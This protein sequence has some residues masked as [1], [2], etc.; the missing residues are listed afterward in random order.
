MYEWSKEV[1]KEKVLDLLLVCP[2]IAKDVIHTGYLTNSSEYKRNRPLLKKKDFY[3]VKISAL[4]PL[5]RI[6]DSWQVKATNSSRVTAHSHLHIS[7][8]HLPHT[9]VLYRNRF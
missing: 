7:H 3:T 6:K 4:H 9:N 5:H 8:S 2:V 1:F